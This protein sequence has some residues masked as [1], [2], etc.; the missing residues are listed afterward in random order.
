VKAFAI[1]LLLSSAAFAQVPP[2]DA[3]CGPQDVSFKVVRDKSQHPTPAPENGKAMLYVFGFGMLA[4]DGSWVGAV[5][6]TGAYFTSQIDPGDHHLCARVIYRT[7]PGVLLPIWKIKDFSFHALDA[8][9]GETYYVDLNMVAYNFRL[10]LLD[11]DQGKYLLASS[12]F[13][14][15]HPK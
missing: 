1:A 4:M 6:G 3:A 15:S 5:D 12:T 7:G 14:A 13:S 8:K 9:P 10:E 2:P 11:P